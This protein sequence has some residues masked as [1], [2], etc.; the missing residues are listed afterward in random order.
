MT[1]DVARTLTNKQVNKIIGLCSF[2]FDR[3]P[4]PDY[5]FAYATYA[6]TPPGGYKTQQKHCNPMCM[7]PSVDSQL[8]SFCHN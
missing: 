7:A 2:K 1:L 3:R 8:N 4:T 5:G 6:Q